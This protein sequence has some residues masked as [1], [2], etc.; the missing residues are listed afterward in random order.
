[1]DQLILR[2][3]PPWSFALRGISVYFFL[4]RTHGKSMI[5]I[6]AKELGQSVSKLACAFA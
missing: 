3:P 1:M 5:T 4:R 2:M 6:R